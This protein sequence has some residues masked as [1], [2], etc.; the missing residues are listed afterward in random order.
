M[1]QANADLCFVWKLKIGN[2]EA[3]LCLPFVYIFIPT[4]R[5]D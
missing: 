1:D 5:R 4:S 2:C 3:I